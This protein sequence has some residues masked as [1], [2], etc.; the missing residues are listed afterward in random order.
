MGLLQL[1]LGLFE[2]Q[3]MQDAF[4][5]ALG[6]GIRKN[7]PA[8]VRAIQP[9][10]GSDARIAKGGA[11][12]RDGGSARLGQPVRDGIG[13]DDGRTVRGEQLG[14]RALAAADT[15]GESDTEPHGAASSCK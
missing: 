3:R 1:R 12:W 7:Q 4:Q 6:G 15:A 8:Q 5:F 2:Y 9:A 10:I 11:Y 13:V 14:H